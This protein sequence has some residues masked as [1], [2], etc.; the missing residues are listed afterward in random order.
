MALIADDRDPALAAHRV[1]GELVGWIVRSGPWL[2]ADTVPLLAYFLLPVIDRLPRSLPERDVR[3]RAL[4]SSGARWSLPSAFSCN[5]RARTYEP[6]SAGARLRSS[7]MTRPS[8]IG[9]WS[10]PQVLRGISD[11]SSGDSIRTV[12]AGSCSTD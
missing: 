12:I 8:G 6:R 4:E 2:L 9:L 5:C 11:L 3:A 10:D 1:V 7:S